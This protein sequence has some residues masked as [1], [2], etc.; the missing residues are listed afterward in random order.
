MT[1]LLP[2][3]LYEDKDVLVINKPAGLLVHGIKAHPGGRTLVAWLIKRYPSI[4]KV[5]DDPELRPGIVHR[6]DKETSGVM[7]VAKTQA[8]FEFL[9]KQFQSRNIR[10]V[11]LAIVWGTFEMHSG[12]IEKPIGIKPGTLKRTIKIDLDTKLVK[13]AKTIYRVMREIGP[14]SV[15]EAEPLTG[16]THQIRVH[17]AAIKHPVVGDR[18]YS[19]RELPKGVSRLML[20]AQSLELTLPN[21][22]TAR[23]TAEPPRDVAAMLAAPEDRHTKR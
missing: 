10:K 16:R 15:V 12:I 4:K 23:F 14:Y 2:K 1:S 22:K 9:K 13:E 18:L 7:I 19:Q 11:Y 8:A 3:V 5:G 21:G 17:L 6:L 20:H